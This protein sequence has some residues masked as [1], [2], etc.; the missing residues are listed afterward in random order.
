PVTQ[1]L[2]DDVLE[3]GAKALE[4]SADLC[5][6]QYIPVD[7]DFDRRLVMR[8]YGKAKSQLGSVGGGNHFI[9]MQVDEARGDVWVMVHCGSR[10]YGWQTANHFFYAGAELRGLAKN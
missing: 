3:H 9:E 5:E 2:G 7:S 4:V 8:A 1:A 10:G 6:R